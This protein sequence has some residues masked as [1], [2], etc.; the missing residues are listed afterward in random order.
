MFFL[1]PLWSLGI[2]QDRP[3]IDSLLS[4]YLIRC[5][6]EGLV[7]FTETLKTAETIFIGDFNAKKS[8]L[9][10]LEYKVQQIISALGDAKVI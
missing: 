9:E 1:D 7:Y 6:S 4:E 10:P 5:V 2:F 3:K 8:K